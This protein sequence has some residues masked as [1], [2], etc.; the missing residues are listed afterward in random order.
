MN[1]VKNKKMEEKQELKKSLTSILI[2]ALLMLGTIFYLYT[3]SLKS[4]LKEQTNLVSS[5]NDTVK[6]WKDKD[7]LNHAKIEVIKTSSNKDFINLQSKDKE[8][9]ELQQLVKQYKKQLSKPGSSATNFTSE[10]KIDNSFGI[11]KDTIET[12]VVGNDTIKLHKY[13]YDISLKDKK[14]IEWV[15]GKAVATKD[16][17]HL[18]QKI[19]NK[20]SVIIG[21]ESQGWFKP[22]KPFVEVIN[23]NPF[24]ETTKVKTYQVETKP[25]KKIGI[26]PGVYYGIGNSFQPQVFVGIGIQYNFI[27]L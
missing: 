3:N 7:G 27:R 15:S 4:Q 21:E 11:K 19:I 2:I 14:G 17:L 22:K 12:K 23:L 1:I 25:I 24:S 10:T 8:I 26:G 16:S 6:I 20:Y 18:E 9:V 13:E 5:L